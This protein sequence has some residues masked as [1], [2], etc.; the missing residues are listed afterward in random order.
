[1]LIWLHFS[2]SVVMQSM[3][4]RE[5][6]GR[7]AYLPPGC[8][9]VEAEWGQEQG[10]LFQSMPSDPLPTTGLTSQKSHQISNPSRDQF[11]D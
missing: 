4:G 11:V 2:G 10:S 6:W 3:M 5:G 8:Q 1:M 9:R 7:P